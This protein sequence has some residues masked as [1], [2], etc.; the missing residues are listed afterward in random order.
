MDLLLL[1]CRYNNWANARMLEV[2]RGVPAAV[3][4][5]ETA[6]TVGSA[7]S[8]LKHLVAVEDRYLAYLRGQD[9]E[10]TMEPENAYNAHDIGWFAD[11][12]T[13]V[14]KDYLVV[15]GERDDASLAKPLGFGGSDW[16]FFT[17]Q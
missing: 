10:T 4:D 2:C 13:T 9:P 14:G 7:G 11:R 1:L 8:T 5:D 3:F 15:L 6:G 12:L 16:D 17:V